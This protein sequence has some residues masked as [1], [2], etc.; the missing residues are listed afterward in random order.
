MPKNFGEDEDDD[1]KMGLTEYHYH[2]YISSDIIHCLDKKKYY[3]SEASFVTA[4]R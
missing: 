2:V 1:T 4:F 3:V